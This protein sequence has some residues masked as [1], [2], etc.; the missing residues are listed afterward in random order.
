ME[1]IGAL[2]QGVENPSGNDRYKRAR[3]PEGRGVGEYH[4]A[5]AASRR[6][7]TDAPT[8]HNAPSH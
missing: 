1:G 2:T 5:S 7:H 8:T 4:R 6:G 3:S